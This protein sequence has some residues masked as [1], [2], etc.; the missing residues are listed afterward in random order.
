M[1]ILNH[2]I[3]HK[4]KAALA[5][6]A[7]CTAVQVSYSQSTKETKDAIAD[8][9]FMEGVWKGTGWVMLGDKKQEFNETET[10]TKK[11]NGYAY[12]NRS[13]WNCSR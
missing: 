8:V 6:V 2:Y 1:S 4:A 3:L 10:V 9:L 5:I 11:L 13:V 12:P 7:L